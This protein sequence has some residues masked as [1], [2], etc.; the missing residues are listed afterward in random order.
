[1]GAF[2]GPNRL[3]LPAL[4]AAW[5]THQGKEEGEV[6]EVLQAAATL[7][8]HVAGWGLLRVP[9][10]ARQDWNRKLV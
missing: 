10:P 4:A 8:A 9:S 1:M 2:S 5:P 7:A 6:R 3:P